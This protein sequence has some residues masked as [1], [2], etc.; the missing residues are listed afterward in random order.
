MHIVEFV[1]LLTISGVCVLTGISALTVDSVDKEHTCSYFF[2]F[3]CLSP[4]ELSSKA[5]CPLPL[6]QGVG[7]GGWLPSL[8][9]IVRKYLLEAIPIIA[10]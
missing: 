5:T 6:I 1:A 7:E 8:A 3:C 9:R 2:F 10:P 4:L